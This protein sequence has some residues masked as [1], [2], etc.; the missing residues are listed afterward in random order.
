MTI[1]VRSICSFDYPYSIG[2]HYW[3]PKVLKPSDTK[4]TEHFRGKSPYSDY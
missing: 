3:Y 2:F 1:H 4:P